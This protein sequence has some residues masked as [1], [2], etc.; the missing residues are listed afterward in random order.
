MY[1]R[2]VPGCPGPGVTYPVGLELQMVVKY[3]CGYWELNPS[4]ERTTH[5]LNL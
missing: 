2:F 4:S 5:V 1:T 3:P